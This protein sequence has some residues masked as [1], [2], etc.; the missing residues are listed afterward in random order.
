MKID[1]KF[2]ENLKTKLKIKEVVGQYVTLTKAGVNYKGICPFHNDS[3]PS[4]V[5]NEA[6]ETY[7]CFV[8]GAH[9]DAIDFLQK[10]NNI[11]FPEAVRLACKIANVEFPKMEATPEEEQAYKLLEARRI[12]IGAA[13]KFYQKN[14]FQA[15][16]FLQSRGYTANDKALADFGV[17]YAPAHFRRV[18]PRCA[19]LSGNTW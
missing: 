9:G 13:A 16:S 15:E 12:A 7:H 3:H 14:L 10:F 6:R 11:S 18:Q 8:C 1:S 19:H 17:G 4:M 2:I 5:V